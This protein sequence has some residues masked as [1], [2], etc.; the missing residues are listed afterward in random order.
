MVKRPFAA[1]YENLTLLFDKNNRQYKQL[2]S[3]DGALQHQLHASLSHITDKSKKIIAYRVKVFLISYIRL[4]GML[5]GWTR[6]A[7]KYIA[8]SRLAAEDASASTAESDHAARANNMNDA[9]NTN[10]VDADA[11]TDD[12]RRIRSNEKQIAS[13]TATTSALPQPVQAQ[14]T[15]QDLM[16]DF[17]ATIFSELCHSVLEE[18]DQLV[19]ISAFGEVLLVRL[20]II[21]I[22]SVHHGASVA[23]AH[24]AG[25]TANASVTANATAS[26][27]ANTNAPTTVG[28]ANIPKNGSSTTAPISAG[29]SA[30]TNE[31]DSRVTEDKLKNYPRILSESLALT[32]TFGFLNK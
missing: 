5:Y 26:V 24:L 23:R 29:S 22:F 9:N 21:C 15:A 18:F 16:A 25:T 30:S 20:L 10:A 1:G 2:K 32:L 4:H 8:A 27:N 19:S 3:G 7:L 14:L 28:A 17:D 6:R 13:A 11:D 12:R 31:Q